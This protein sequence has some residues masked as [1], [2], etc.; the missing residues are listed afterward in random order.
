MLPSPRVAVEAGRAIAILD[1]SGS[2]TCCWRSSGA[3]RARVDPTAPQRLGMCPDGLRGADHAELE[4]ATPEGTG[5]AERHGHHD[6]QAARCSSSSSRGAGPEG[7]PGFPVARTRRRAGHSV[8]CS[9]ITN[10]R[11]G[12]IPGRSVP[13][14]DGLRFP[15]ALALESTARPLALQVGPH[16]RRPLAGKLQVVRVMPRESVCP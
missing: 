12:S 8:F 1:V 13:W 6:R 5:R 4:R 16:G 3:R 10:R 15:E 2:S 7:E 14:I 9:R 11:A